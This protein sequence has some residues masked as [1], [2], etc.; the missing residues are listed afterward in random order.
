MEDLDKA[1]YQQQKDWEEEQEFYASES[2]KAEAEMKVEEENEARRIEME[3]K[4]TLTCDGC[5]ESF[6]SNEG[7]PIHQ[8]CPKCFALLNAGRKEVVE[9]IEKILID[10]VVDKR[11][12]KLE[13][14]LFHW[15][16]KLKENGID[17]L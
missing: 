5:G 15:Q 10:I 6:Y 12:D 8:L 4:Y 13:K 17:V 11:V 1:L 7:F 16:A 14:L 2:A 3:I 9:D